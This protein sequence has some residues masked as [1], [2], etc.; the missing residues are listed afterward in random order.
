MNVLTKIL[1]L[2]IDLKDKRIFK[3]CKIFESV[4][5]TN[6]LIDNHNSGRNIH[7]K[8]LKNNKEFN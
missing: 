4:R 6:T 8:I 1:A 2:R 5:D 3:E 7:K